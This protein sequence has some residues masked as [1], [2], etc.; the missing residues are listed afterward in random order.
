MADSLASSSSAYSFPLHQDE[1]TII[2]Q[3]LHVPAIKDPW[4][5]KATEKVKEQNEDMN[6][7]TLTAVSLLE[8]DE[9]PE[10]ELPWFYHIE[11]YL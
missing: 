5:A 8:A 10:E 1:E 11:A 4:F 6:T 2:L 9:E 7:G 3:R